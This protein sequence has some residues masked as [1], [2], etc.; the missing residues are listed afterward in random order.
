[1]PRFWVN[2]T[3]TTYLLGAVWEA[4]LHVKSVLNIVAL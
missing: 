2:G 1:M 3:S 4:K